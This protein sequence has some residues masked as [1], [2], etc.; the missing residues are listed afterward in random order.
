M[1][2]IVS[3]GMLWVRGPKKDLFSHCPAKVER[4]SYT[5]LI[6]RVFEE[7]LPEKNDVKVSFV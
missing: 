3:V 7:Q 4:L 6:L 1:I 2:K 5:L